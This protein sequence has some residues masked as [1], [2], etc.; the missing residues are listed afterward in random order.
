MSGTV[1]IAGDQLVFEIHGID[2]I[3]SIR[4]SISVPLERVRPVSTGDPGWAPR[5]PYYP[6]G[7]TGDACTSRSGI[8]RRGRR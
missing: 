6:P 3:P 2:G 5:S 7:G 1:R 8:A 4:R